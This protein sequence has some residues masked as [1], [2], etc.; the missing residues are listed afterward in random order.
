MERPIGFSELSW[1]VIKPAGICLVD[2]RPSRCE[3]FCDGKDCEK[4]HWPSATLPPA[5]KRWG[6]LR[7]LARPVGRIFSPVSM[8]VSKPAEGARE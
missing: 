2:L 7:E 6:E 4:T 1:P 3:G 5:V 8:N